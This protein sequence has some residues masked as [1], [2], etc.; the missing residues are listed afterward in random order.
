MAV[1]QLPDRVRDFAT[2]L[3]GL[4]TRID[5]GAGW[6]GV[7]WQ[8]DPD[9]MRA[10]LD[11]REVPPWDVVE[12]LL[13]DLAADHGPHA[14]ETETVR[15]RTLHTASLAALDARP[16]ALEALGNRLDVMLREQRY[17]ADRRRELGRL[18]AAAP[19]GDEVEAVRQDLAWATDDHDRAT[20]RCAELRARM[21]DLGRRRAARGDPHGT[22][23]DGRTYPHQA[24]ARPQYPG[25]QAQP[26]QTQPPQAPQPSQAPYSPQA[27]PAQPHPQHSQHPQQFAQQPHPQQQ[28][29]PERPYPRHPSGDATASEPH[30]GQIWSAWTP[31]QRPAPTPAWPEGFAAPEPAGPGDRPPA[32]P[33]DLESAP[34][35]DPRPDRA[36]DPAPAPTPEPPSTVPKQRGRRLRGARFAGLDNEGEDRA[37]DEAPATPALPTPAPTGRTPRGA[38]FA[39]AAEEPSG[40]EPALTVPDDE[41]RRATAEAVRSLVRLRAEGRSGEAHGVL[42]EAAYWPAERFPL[43]AVELRRAGLAADWSTLLWEAA[44]LPADRLVALADTLT[45]AGGTEDGALLLRQGVAR[46]P[47][48]IGA[49]VLD[50]ADAGRTRE[51]RALLDA[52]VRVRTP[53]EAARSVENDPQRL[54]PLLLAAAAGVSDERRWDLVHA[55]R[56]AG[57]GS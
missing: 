51:V 8:R 57:H 6:C 1:D 30:Q 25:Q 41:S 11:G 34:R 18:L 42:V 9:G 17:A 16:G 20:A 27:Q 14:A 53:E 43:L 39:G 38:R 33:P 19:S 32:P 45:A 21:A 23:R 29:A 48:E 15:A 26:Q 31:P 55:L 46:P 54:V 12:A 24:Q 47:D 49:T 28:F 36:P 13:Q 52:Y 7:F 3:N 5:Q 56:V 37:G 22:A 50:L 10:C 40:P 44:S 4:L 35:P 2:Y